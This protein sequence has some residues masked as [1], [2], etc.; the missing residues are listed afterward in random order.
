MMSITSD[1]TPDPPPP[2]PRGAP[3]RIKRINAMP[4]SLAEEHSLYEELNKSALNDA[5][6]IRLRRKLALRN[7]LA[8]YL[9]DG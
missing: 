3:K 5:A 1:G 7:V 4:I 8:L 9:W 6:M 2:R